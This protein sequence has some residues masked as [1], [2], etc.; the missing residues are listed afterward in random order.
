[1]IMSVRTKGG[2]HTI[3]NRFDGF[4]NQS[5]FCGIILSDLPINP[6]WTA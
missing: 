3:G 4:F 1:M 5:D 2:G 6:P